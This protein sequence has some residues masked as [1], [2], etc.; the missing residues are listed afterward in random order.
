M[1]N[2]EIPLNNQQ[3]K[4]KQTKLKLFQ[5]LLVVVLIGLFIGFMRPFGMDQYTLFLSMS[6][7]VFTCLCGY[8]I[9]MPLISVGHKYLAKSVTTPWHRVAISSLLASLVMSLIV[10]FI[11]WLFF[12]HT[13]QLNH[14]FL[15]ALPNTLV[16]GSIITFTSMLQNHLHHQ[17]QQLELSKL[18]IEQSKKV[19]EQH[20][21]S[22]DVNTIQI[23][24]FMALLPLEKRGQLLCLEMDDH[25]LKVHTD[26][27]QHMLLMRLK[28]A[29]VQLEGFPG[30]Q[31]HRS[32]WV[33][34]QAVVSVSKENRKMSLLLSN[35]LEVPV[36]RTFAEA[37]KANLAL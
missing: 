13:L 28:D 29:L 10:P 35:H 11:G 20:Q 16:I 32:W 2:R 7:W 26:K 36:S 18:V 33:A 30:L 37:V 4:P 23:E 6:Y 3:L 24:Q 19:I 22:Q 5:Q 25:Y 27:G 1:T 14:H 34:N 15:L 8:L 31:T 12:D 21:Q 17:K 9:Y